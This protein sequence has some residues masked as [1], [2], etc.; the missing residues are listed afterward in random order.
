MNGIAGRAAIQQARAV[1]ERRMS[2]AAGWLPSL[3]RLSADVAADSN[4]GDLR[5]L[6]PQARTADDDLQDAAG[7]FYFLVGYSAVGNGDVI[8]P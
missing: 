8:K 1:E 3:H 2:R 6:P 5:R 7:A 4:I